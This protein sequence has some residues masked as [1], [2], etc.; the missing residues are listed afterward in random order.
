MTVLSVAL[1][2]ANVLYP[3]TMR[4]LLMWLAVTKT[5]D[6]HWTERIQNEGTRNLLLDQPQLTTQRLERTKHLMDQALPGALVTGYED[7]MDDLELPDMNDRH[8]LAAAI[9]SEAQIIVTLNLRD[10]PPSALEP[11]GI[12]ALHPDD[13]ALALT[14]RDPDGVL[15]AVNGQRE[16]FKQPPLTRVEYLERLRRQ[17]LTGFTDWLMAHSPA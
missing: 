5:Y 7:R 11:Y 12:R 10:F 3:T 2:D 1:L 8:V 15:R 9:H 14:E 16:N 6:A 13:F 17:G 4:D